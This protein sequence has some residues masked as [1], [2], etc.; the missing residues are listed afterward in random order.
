MSSYDFHP[1]FISCTKNKFGVLFFIGHKSLLVVQ[2]RKVYKLVRNFHVPCIGAAEQ[3][4][5]FLRVEL[6][7]VVIHWIHLHQFDKKSITYIYRKV[8]RKG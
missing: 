4:R 7:V 6:A 1:Q 2:T 5:E 8:K 3:A